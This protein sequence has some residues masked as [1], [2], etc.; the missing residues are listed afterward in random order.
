MG[1]LYVYDPWPDAVDTNG[2]CGPLVPTKATCTQEDNGDFVLDIQHP[3]DAAGKW[4]ALEEDNLIAANVPLP[5]APEFVATGSASLV[6]TIYAATVNAVSHY[7][8]GV[9]LRG[10]DGSVR[11]FTLPVGASVYVF[12]TFD[13][14]CRIRWPG[15]NGWMDATAL[16]VSATP[17]TLGG[18]PAAIE[19]YIPSPPSRK[20]L[21]R[22]H[23]VERSGTG[24]TAHARHVFY[25][26]AGDNVT[27]AAS[28]ISCIDAV[29]QLYENYLGGFYLG[30]GFCAITSPA[31]I[32]GWTRSG[33]CE[34]FLSPSNGIAA[35]WDAMI[36]RENWDTIVLPRATRDRGYAIEYG[37]NMLGVKFSLDMSDL[38]TA[39]YP[40][41]QTSKGK[42]LTVAPDTYNVDGDYITCGPIVRSPLIDNYPTPHI[43]VM[44]YGSKIKAA[45]TTAAQVLA[46]RVKLIR[47][48]LREFSEKH[49]DTPPVTLNVDFLHLGDTAEYAQY[50]DLQKLFLYDTV[51][52]RHPRLGIDVTTQVNKTEWDCLLDR[53]N[54]IE[55]GSVRKNYART[56][57]APWQVP[58]LASLKSYVDTISNFI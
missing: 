34:A 27:L 43:R 15:G 42:P 49:I 9:Y 17:I 44:D 51:R 20:Q 7:L 36:W 16:T 58:G 39:V 45:G 35:T 11:M 25:D 53:Y 48:A 29:T 40:L 12:E 8:R 56:R 14:W 19:A 23:D 5:T 37:K 57:V 13:D 6:T 54:S 31:D 26:M 55:L 2:L 1:Q 47:E 33:F 21:F 46:A 3:I 24:I 41:G 10:Y 32:E 22:I 4:S 52:V 50:K 38:V 18:T 28:N 30:R